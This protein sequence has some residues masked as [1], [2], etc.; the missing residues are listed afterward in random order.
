VLIVCCSTLQ[1]IDG[2]L[3]ATTE[4]KSM[5]QVLKEMGKTTASRSMYVVSYCQ[6]SVNGSVPLLLCNNGHVFHPQYAGLMPKALA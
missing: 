3:T 4:K 5:R 2:S 1:H 6:A